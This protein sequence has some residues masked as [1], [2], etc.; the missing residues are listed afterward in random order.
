LALSGLTKAVRI[1]VNQQMRFKQQKGNCSFMQ[2]QK[3]FLIWYCLGK[4]TI[5]LNGSQWAE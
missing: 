4:E 2:K 1:N 3:G 5:D